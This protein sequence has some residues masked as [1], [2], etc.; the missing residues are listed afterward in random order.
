V[1][2]QGIHKPLVVGPNPTLGTSKIDL[3]FVRSS[4]EIQV[5]D[6]LWIKWVW[7]GGLK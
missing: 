2:E 3:E 4:A 5:S 1:V 7:H 6:R